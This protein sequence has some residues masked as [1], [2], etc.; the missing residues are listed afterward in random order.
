MAPDSFQCNFRVSH[1]TLSVFSTAP[2]AENSRIHWFYLWTHLQ[3]PYWP[4]WQGALY[5]MSSGIILPSESQWPHYPSPIHLAP[6]SS[7]SE[8]PRC[9][10]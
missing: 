9:M 8:G 4:I 7:V 1:V 3:G 6:G 2:L 10:I 5:K